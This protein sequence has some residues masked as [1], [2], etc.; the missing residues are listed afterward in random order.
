[1]G[2]GKG[3]LPNFGCN[4]SLEGDASDFARVVL[5]FLE[6]HPAL[7]ASPVVL[8]GESYGGARATT[9]LHLFYH[10]AETTIAIADDLR[11]AIDAHY[12]AIFPEA[13]GAKGPVS[14]E[15]AAKQ[16]GAFLLIQPLVL[17]QLQYTA[18]MTLYPRD[19]Y[20]GARVNDTAYDPYDLTKPAG[21]TNTLDA[22]AV[23]ALADETAGPMLLGVDLKSI[24]ELLPPARHDAFRIPEAQL[25]SVA[26]WNAADQTANTLLAAHLGAL[27]KDDAY[28]ATMGPACTAT[29]QALD[30][31][32]MGFWFLDDLLYA[33]LF[34][35]HARW[36]GVIYTPSIPY[37]LENAGI[38]T[39][40][41]TAP[42]AGFAR[43]GWIRFTDETADGK[44]KVPVEIRFPS[45][46]DSGHMVAVTQGS[47]LAADAEQWLSE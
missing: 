29:T 4:F 21:W 16:F 33:R 24:P 40:V 1:M 43:P 39:T 5:A 23:L 20:V 14:P 22:R 28:V 32:D 8:V 38:H 42:R 34:L 26:G 25:V 3:A 7:R 30:A 15:V 31:V 27:E 37:V 36:D 46:D 9:L 41:D 19:P 10:Y 12:R 2:D 18:Q 11:S 17:G 44:T 13:S 6:S 47:D 35:T 45:Y